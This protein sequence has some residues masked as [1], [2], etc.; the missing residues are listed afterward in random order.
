[1]LMEREKE[2]NRVMMSRSRQKSSKSHELEEEQ[3]CLSL[4]DVMLD[5]N[6][7]NYTL[8]CKCRANP[9]LITFVLPSPSP[10]LPSVVVVLGVMTVALLSKVLMDARQQPQ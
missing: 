1:M 3:R 5:Y 4:P 10:S 8:K 9:I 7:F 6:T 2:V